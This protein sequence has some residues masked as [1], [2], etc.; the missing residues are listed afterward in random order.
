MKFAIDGD[1][2]WASDTQSPTSK[3]IKS[4][5]GE[6]GESFVPRSLVNGSFVE[7]FN[8]LVISDGV[9]VNV[10]FE[11]DISTANNRPPEEPTLIFP[12]DNATDV[13]LTVEFKWTSTDPDD[14][15]IIYTL[16]VR[17]STNEEILLFEN[18]EDTIYNLEDLRLGETYFWQVSATDDINPPV[19][20]NF[21]S[22]TTIAESSNRFYFARK[23]G[24]NNVIY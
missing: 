15:L 2:D 8:A 17:N 22:F 11:L 19:Q 14:D 4:Q 12:I 3:A 24:D 18:L 20:S 13:D 10:V 21:S 1:V 5:I 9:T 7:T 16:E 23:E 6:V